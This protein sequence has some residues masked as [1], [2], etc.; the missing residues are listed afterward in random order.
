MKN[1]P[2]RPRGGQKG[3]QNARKHGFYSANLLPREICDFWN[4]VN[5]GGA[6]PEL[7]VLRLKLTSAL[8]Y[9]PGNRRVLGEASRLLVKWYRSRYHLD[10]KDNAEL[11]KFVRNILLTAGVAP[12]SF[13]RDES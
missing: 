8:N 9:D 11:K 3:N 7:A 1:K 2:K 4:I 6:A 10:R 5:L 12:G 13:L